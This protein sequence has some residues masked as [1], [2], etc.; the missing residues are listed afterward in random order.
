MK[1]ILLQDVP[2]V[3]RRLEIKTVSEGFARNYLF[4]KKLAS[5]AT[6][7]AILKLEQEREDEV[8]RAKQELSKTQ[9]LASQLDGLEIEIPTRISERG[10]TYGS[11]SNQ[12]IAQI[13][14]SMGYDIKKSQVV[15]KEIIKKLG[16]YLVTITLIHGLEAE[17]R[18]T[19]VEEKP[20]IQEQP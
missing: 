7:A 5:V 10:E 12:K 2:K 17:I 4:P 9:D 20:P 1:V 15:L 13:L 3:G 16:S 19:I 8:E 18:V 6:P 11:I 14:Q